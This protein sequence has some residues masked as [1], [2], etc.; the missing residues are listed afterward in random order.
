[1]L[2]IATLLAREGLAGVAVAG[3]EKASV[4]GPAPTL[5]PGADADG[6]A[7]PSRAEPGLPSPLLLRNGEC[8]SSG[9]PPAAFGASAAA[10]PPCIAA[11]AVAARRVVP[12]PQLAGQGPPMA[13]RRPVHVSTGKGSTASWR[14]D[15]MQ[16]LPLLPPAGLAPPTAAAS[17]ACACSAARCSGWLAGRSHVLTAGRTLHSCVG[18]YH[19]PYAGPA[20]ALSAPHRAGPSTAQGSLALGAR[21]AP[22]RLVA[23]SLR[24]NAARGWGSAPPAA[25]KPV[26]AKPSARLPPPPPLLLLSPGLGLP[27][28]V[29]CRP[30]ES[31]GGAPGSGRPHAPA[32]V[33]RALAGVLA[34][35]STAAAS[36]ARASSS[37]HAAAGRV[38]AC[39]GVAS[40]HTHGQDA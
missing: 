8:A 10:A 40:H 19:A 29:Q 20:L 21:G 30:G 2:V 9:T 39:S 31:H 5:L 4:N 34:A 3:A 38:H 17:S 24:L 28:C 23:A 15:P 13:C 6:K 22:R 32:C 25:P 27:P 12:P 16:P 37:S 33:P 14:A 18:R 35:A 26:R 11:A 36:W 1:M 7:P